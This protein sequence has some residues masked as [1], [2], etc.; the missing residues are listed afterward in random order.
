MFRQPGTER[1]FL[2]LGYGRWWRR[3]REDSGVQLRWHD[4]RHTFASR[5]LRYGGDL[6]S[7]QQLMGHAKI[8]MTMRYAKLVTAGLR[9]HV[10]QME[11]LRAEEEAKLA[12]LSGTE[13]DTV[14]L[15]GKA[16]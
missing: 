15:V 13:L 11:R 4:L 5:F 3:V 7:L 16:S 2:R 8:E 6:A 12:K 1:P 9:F 14:P 10:E